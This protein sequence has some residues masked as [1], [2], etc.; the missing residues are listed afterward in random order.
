MATSVKTKY[1]VFLNHLIEFLNRK[2]LKG[3][4]AQK[5]HREF[6]ADIEAAMQP[7]RHAGLQKLEAR[8]YKAG[9]T[10]GVIIDPFEKPLFGNWPMETVLDFG[11]EKFRVQD[12]VGGGGSKSFKGVLYHH[13]YWAIREGEFPMLKKCRTCS[14]FF[15]SHRRDA[16][17]CSPKCNQR[18]HVSKLRERGYYAQNYKTAKKVKLANA[19]KLKGKPLDVIM[20]ESGLTRLALIRAKIVDEEEQV[21]KSTVAQKGARQ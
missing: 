7:P 20:R 19:R 3:G 21:T 18:F 5:F 12:H 9:L 10:W 15:A 2:D 16:L 17:A 8:I 1:P 11:D 6:K 13:L 14:K 4:D